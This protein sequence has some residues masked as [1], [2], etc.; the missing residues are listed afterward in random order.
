M[1][2]SMSAAGGENID[3]CVRH[4]DQGIGRGQ[5]E[6]APVKQSFG[7]GGHAAVVKHVLGDIRED[8]MAGRAEP[9]QHAERDEAVTGAHVKQRVARPQ[10]SLVEHRIP[11]RIQ[12][13]GEV[14]LPV[15]SI[16]SEPPVE[17]PSMPAVRT[18]CHDWPFCL[19]GCASG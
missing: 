18:I 9:L 1:A 11:D 13:L 3:R 10:L 15:G 6:A 19:P 12:E 16:A 8:H 17:K 7:G 5:Q 2:A 14:L 4:A